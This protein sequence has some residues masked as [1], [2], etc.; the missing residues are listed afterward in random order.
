MKSKS[1]NSKELQKSIANCLKNGIP[2][3]GLI[4]A[5]ISTTGCDRISPVTTGD[6]PN[7]SRMEVVGKFPANED[8]DNY[9]QTQQQE[10][11]EQPQLAGDIAPKEPANDKKPT[12][13]PNEC[14]VPEKNEEKLPPMPGVPPQPK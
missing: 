13:K 2:L 5:V 6:V 12:P 1:R 8:I 10:K 7:N 3:A 14:P 4:S 11:D 9:G